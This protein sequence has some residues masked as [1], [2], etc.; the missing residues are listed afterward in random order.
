MRF[1]RFMCLQSP[2]PPTDHYQ[3]PWLSRS[4]QM[5]FLIGN[6]EP[7]SVCGGK[8]VF[9]NENLL[10]LNVSTKLVNIM[11]YLASVL[12]SAEVS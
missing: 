11:Q 1:P 6:Q 12:K 9:Y 2:D 4:V 3:G 7:F 8:L 5:Q 10:G